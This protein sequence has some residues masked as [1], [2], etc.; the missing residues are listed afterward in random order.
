MASRALVP[1]ELHELVRTGVQSALYALRH[2]VVFHESA[3]NQ[4]TRA[5]QSLVR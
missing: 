3:P 2:L 1:P 4:A 5:R